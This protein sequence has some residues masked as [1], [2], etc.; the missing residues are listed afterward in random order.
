[1]SQRRPLS[2]YERRVNF[3]NCVAFGLA[4]LPS[5]P[6]REQVVAKAEQIAKV[7]SYEGDLEDCISTIIEKLRVLFMRG[8]FACG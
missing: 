2:A 1:M 4:T 3:T 8:R 7:L 5:L 6:T